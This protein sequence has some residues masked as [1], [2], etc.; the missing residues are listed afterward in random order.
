MA[1][2]IVGGGVQGHGL[3]VRNTFLDIDDRSVS[4]Q[5]PRRPRAVSDLTDAKL[6]LKVQLH[7]GESGMYQ[8]SRHRLS[9]TFNDTVSAAPGPAGLAPVT[10]DL[11]EAVGG[12]TPK[13]PGPPASSATTTGAS[14]PASSAPE[15]A[16]AAGLFPCFG[17]VPPYPMAYGMPWWYGGGTGVGMPVPMHPAVGSGY[18]FW[19]GFD[20]TLPTS[21]S[22][23]YGSGCGKGSSQLPTQQPSAGSRSPQMKA[24]RSQLQ[25][26]QHIRGEAPIGASVPEK[27]GNMGGGAQMPFPQACSGAGRAEAPHEV[28]IRSVNATETP[29]V[30]AGEPTTVMLRNIPNRYTQA[31]LLQLLSDRRCTGLYDF[32]YLPMDFRNG[33]NLGYA[34][35]NLLRHADAVKFMT[36]FQGFSEWLVDSVKV[37]ETSWAH[38][39]QGFDE[40][41]ER[42]RNSP[43]MHQR[44]PDEYKPMVFWNGV[45]IPFPPPTKAIKAPKLR[46]IRDRGNVQAGNS[47]V[48][49]VSEGGQASGLVSVCA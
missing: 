19:G 21:G 7:G 17:G 8:I 1:P 5:E 20:G 13:G 41:V 27:K 33:V 25:L 32:V 9:S 49:V 11:V 40:H 22:V 12:D 43:V 42:Y 39:H 37:C 23:G 30:P 18:P 6:P 31:M 24:A 38:P 46:L 26:S 4:P 15:A 36:D 48:S 44:M 47:Q 35:V 3:V 16:A 29:A 28:P 2:G 45:R 14:V 34:F 10:E